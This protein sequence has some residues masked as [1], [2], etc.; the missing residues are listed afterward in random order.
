MAKAARILVAFTA[1]LLIHPG[2][3]ALA[4]EPETFILRVEALFDRTD[5]DCPVLVDNAMGIA[6]IV[7]S[8][9]NAVPALDIAALETLLASAVRQRL[10]RECAAMAR[11]RTPGST[12]MLSSRPAGDALVVTTRRDGSMG[13]SAQTVV[14]RLVRG[15]PWGW[16]IADI[17]AEGRGLVA[18]LVG[19]ANGALGAAP[20]DPDA[21]IRAI[22]R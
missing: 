20:D 19:D 14:W 8:I 3:G 7:R 17:R 13:P 11:S 2:R 9:R 12:V 10:T 16:R 4:A 5:P 1:L 22:A 18:T 21:A 6:Q 15:G